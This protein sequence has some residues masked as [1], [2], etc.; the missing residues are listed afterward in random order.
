MNVIYKIE[1][2]I[3]GKCYVGQS[4][5]LEVRLR[6]HK[7]AVYNKSNPGYNYPLY[8]AARK[9]GW[10]NF[11]VSIIEEVESQDDLTSR[12]LYWY[13]KLEPEYNQVEPTKTMTKRNKPLYMIDMK[14]LEIVK[15]F[16]GFR[17]A[18]RHFG[19]SASQ[20][21]DVSNRKRKSAKNHYWC[22]VDD[23]TEDWEPP[24]PE[25]VRRNKGI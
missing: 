25:E 15:E 19:T 1:N 7:S 17:D 6:A 5:D 24:T 22:F 23:Y 8:R 4:I 21:S 18:Q 9:Y 11:E 13:D 10:E 2:L 16:K 14:T 3:N 20:V 12:E